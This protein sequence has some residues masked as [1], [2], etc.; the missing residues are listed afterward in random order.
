MPRLSSWFV[1]AA[2]IYLAIGFTLGALI[3]ANKGIAFAPFIWRLLPAHMEILLVGWFGELAMGVI[4]W[5]LPRL[6]PSLSRGKESWI[7]LAWGL[8]NLGIVLVVVGSLSQLPF[9]ILF[10]RVGECAAVLVFVLGSW[11]RV[12]PFAPSK[13]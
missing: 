4:Y 13:T 9:L 8:L 1:R 11:A 6:G 10:G 12:R 3:L 7:W 5:I 2:L